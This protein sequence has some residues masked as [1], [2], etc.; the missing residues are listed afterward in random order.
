[1]K[2][3]NAIKSVLYYEVIMSSNSNNTFILKCSFAVVIRLWWGH[4]VIGY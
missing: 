4:G 1:M 2:Q 3:K